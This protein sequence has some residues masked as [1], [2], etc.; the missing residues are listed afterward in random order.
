MSKAI[1]ICVLMSSGLTSGGASEIAPSSALASRP[2][3]SKRAAFDQACRDATALI[4]Y[5]RYE[6]APLSARAMANVRMCNGHPLQSICENI[7]KTVLQEYGKTPFTCG[8]NIADSVPSV[9]LPDKPS[10]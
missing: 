2:D 8:S 7:S 10:R 6:E 9:F 1:L 4:I 5:G 3:M